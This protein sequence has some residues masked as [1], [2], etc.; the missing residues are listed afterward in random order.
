MRI[1]DMN[2][3]QVAAYLQRDDVWACHIVDD[4]VLETASPC[5]ARGGT[6]VARVVDVTDK[7]AVDA[8]VG[9]VTGQVLSIDGGK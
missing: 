6:C 5:T 4:E 1:A 7:H 8:F 9:W 2:W 3:M